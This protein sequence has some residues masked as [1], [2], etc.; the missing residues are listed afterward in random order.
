M[1]RYT[2]AN[3]IAGQYVILAEQVALLQRQLRAC[4]ILFLSFSFYT[5]KVARMQVAVSV[6]LVFFFITSKF[7]QI[8][9]FFAFSKKCKSGAKR[10]VYS[11]F[12]I[13]KF[14][15]FRVRT[16]ANN[17]VYLLFFYS[18]FSPFFYSV[19]ANF[20]HILNNTY[21]TSFSHAHAN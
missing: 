5:K 21:Y 9:L 16:N 13:D 15:S 4:S 18:F 19:I 3:K 10:W 17:K 11:M 8:E 20:V 6:A 14:F 7:V 2:D 1:H 12:V